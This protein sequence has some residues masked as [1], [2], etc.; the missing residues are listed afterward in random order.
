MSNPPPQSARAYGR[1]R[2]QRFFADRMPSLGAA[3]SS[4][5][6]RALSEEELAELL[7]AAFTEGFEEGNR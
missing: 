4:T 3:E 1:K 6:T 7:A 5:G 2:A